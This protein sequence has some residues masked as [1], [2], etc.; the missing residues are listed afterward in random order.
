MCK[1]ALAGRRFIV[2]PLFILLF[3]LLVLAGPY[4]K[5][6]TLTLNGRAYNAYVADN[7][8][9]RA[10]G[11]MFRDPLDVKRGEC[12]VFEFNSGGPHWFWML[13]VHFDIDLYTK[14]S[15]GTYKKACTMESGSL[16]QVC[17]A[18]RSLVE[19]KR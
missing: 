4:R 8:I 6:R 15:K 12:M 9:A 10:I 5:V 13:D 14:G 19:V 17:V 11:Y 1:I 7:F 16:R 18:G 3:P 2:S